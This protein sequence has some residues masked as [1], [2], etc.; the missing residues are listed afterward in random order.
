M[1]MVVLLPCWFAGR[2]KS[3]YD[4]Q[5]PPAVYIVTVGR[6]GKM[7]PQCSVSA[8]GSVAMGA[9][10][11]SSDR[12]RVNEFHDLCDGSVGE[13]AGE[14]GGRDEWVVW[15]GPDCTIGSKR[16]LLW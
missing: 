6:S 12:W 16:N 7:I 3:A 15:G 2:M 5:W 10:V 14:A 8:G 9:A 13:A 1:E 11:H 4:P